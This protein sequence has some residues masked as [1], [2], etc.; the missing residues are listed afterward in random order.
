MRR[1]CTKQSKQVFIRQQD[2]LEERDVDCGW[3]RSKEVK[4]GWRGR[5]VVPFWV[6]IRGNFILLSLEKIFLCVRNL[7]PSPLYTSSFSSRYPIQTLL[8]PTLEDV[9]HQVFVLGLR[10][11]DLDDENNPGSNA[12]KSR[13]VPVM[14]KCKV[15]R[16]QHVQLLYA[17]Q[18]VEG[19]VHMGEYIVQ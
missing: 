12:G 19:I 3:L 16:L 10:A 18:R 8:P 15:R 4:G 6:A 13:A 2:S 7:S 9:A 11:L 17:V 5:V 1:P 14:R